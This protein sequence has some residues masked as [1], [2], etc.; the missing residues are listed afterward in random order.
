MW[1]AGS[2]A[3]AAIPD[4]SGASDGFSH[5]GKEAEGSRVGSG[6]LHVPGDRRASA[7]CTSSPQVIAE[8]ETGGVGA[9]GVAGGVDRGA[10]HGAE[11]ARRGVVTGDAL[12]IEQAGRTHEARNASKVLPVRGG[13]MAKTM[14]LEQWPGVLAQREGGKGCQVRPGRTS[15]RLQTHAQ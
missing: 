6:R 1:T 8:F 10:S 7:R 2:A 3:A 9:V 14:P 13:L 5:S 12:V 4:T 11:M 15:V